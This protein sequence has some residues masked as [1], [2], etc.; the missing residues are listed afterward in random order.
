M[1]RCG[2]CERPLRIP[3]QGIEDAAFVRC[4]WCGDGLSLAAVIGAES[5]G[6]RPEEAISVPVA[7]IPQK[8]ADTP[9]PKAPADPRPA[10]QG[11]DWLEK[12]ILPDPKPLV[13]EMPV[14]ETSS[15][16]LAK[17]PENSQDMRRHR[18]HAPR[19]DWD[20]RQTEQPVRHDRPTSGVATLA[21]IGLG[22]T[23]AAVIVVFLLQNVGRLDPPPVVPGTSDEPGGPVVAS[24]LGERDGRPIDLATDYPDLQDVVA[25]FLKAPSPEALGPLI[26]DPGRVTPLVDDYYATVPYRILG[27]RSMAKR[28]AVRVVEDFVLLTVETRDYD[29]RSVAVEKT[30]DGFRVDWESFVGYSE[31]PWL[32]LLVSPPS[33]PVLVRAI[34]AEDTY[35]NY[36]FADEEALACFALLSP[37]HNIKIYGYTPRAS[38]DAHKLSSFLAEASDGLVTLRIR[39][40]ENPQTNNQVWIDDFIDEG[41]VIGIPD[42]ALQRQEPDI[43]VPAVPELAIPVPSEAELA[44]PPAD[45]QPSPDLLLEEPPPLLGD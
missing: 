15:P 17:D 38:A 25:A 34:A 14:R 3:A 4:P 35:Y 33:E 1:L 44:D 16:E 45:V 5:G 29:R 27:F 7:E 30:A 37:D 23:V 32:D 43:S 10:S 42:A 11:A 20:K 2:G 9:V 22:V 6:E 24:A 21:I 41:W 26:R 13:F 19:N 31:M 28:D 39:Y 40:P 18:S 8:E 36:G 12:P